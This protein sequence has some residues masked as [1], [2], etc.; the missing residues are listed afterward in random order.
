M[1][2][3]M[4]SMRVLSHLALSCHCIPSCQVVEALRPHGLT[5]E[6]YASVREQQIG[7]FIQASGSGRNGWYPWRESLGVACLPACLPA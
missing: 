1:S 2:V 7:G 4:K 5:L 6:N 3:L